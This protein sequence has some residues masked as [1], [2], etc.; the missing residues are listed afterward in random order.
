[1]KRLVLLLAIAGCDDALDQRLSLVDE[2]RIL[3]VTA[4]PAEAKPGTMVSYAALIAS[5]DG[6]VADPLAWSYCIAGK[7]PTEDNAVSPFCLG[8]VSIVALGTAPSVTATLPLDVCRVFGP[9]VPDVG[10]R[11]RDPDPSGGYYVPVRADHDDQRAFGLS[12]ITCLLPD[13]TAEVQRAYAQ[14]YR[15]N[16][17]PV[18]LEPVFPPVAAGSST[19][20]AIAWTPESVETYLYY[21]RA[22][23]ELIERAETL[24]ASWY[25]T[26][27]EFAADAT[28]A[29][30][31]T[32][33][34]PPTPGPVHVWI[35]LRDSR[36][37][38]A[39]RA[40]DLTIE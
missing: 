6:T 11:P 13:V 24:R 32:F 35:V 30:A 36:G 26:A 10:Y 31:N 17:A 27:G 8:D 7:P 21:D 19:E 14:D 29:P 18:L 3:A 4:D 37:G 22:S 25:A 1:M 5:P 33:R 28:D 38:I 16:V 23:G 20:L 39:T 2:P 9:E 12:R 15:A 40:V 34:A